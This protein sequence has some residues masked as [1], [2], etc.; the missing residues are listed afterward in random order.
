VEREEFQYT[1]LRVVPRIERGERLNV[2]LV[3]FSPRHRFLAARVHVDR[4]RLA[5]LDPDAPAEEIERHLGSLA[6]VAAGDPSGG[7]VAQLPAG[8]RFHWLAA[9][10][11]TVIQPSEVHTGFC[12]DP[13]AELDRL[14]E[15][16]VG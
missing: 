6:A 16:L 1:L 4:A 11:S 9:P 10:S 15:Q 14:F 8:E 12:E 7:P 3:L 5:A 2:G 13:Q